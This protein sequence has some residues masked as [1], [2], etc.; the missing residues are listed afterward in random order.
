MMQ[1]AGSA[2]RLTIADP[3]E[4]PVETLID[5]GKLP[6]PEPECALNTDGKWEKRV[7]LPG[8]ADIALVYAPVGRFLMG[9]TGVDEEES[10]PQHEVTI[11]APFWLGKYEITQVQ[12]KA[13]LASRPSKFKGDNLP[14]ENVTWH[15]A[16]TFPG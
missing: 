6:Q 8:G 5:P 11:G 7:A 13:V 9:S 10:Q 15:D 4:V 14:V 1:A 16:S 12:W 3:D 2:A